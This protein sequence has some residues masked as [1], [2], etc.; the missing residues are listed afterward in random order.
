M[1]L[2][3][4]NPIFALALG[5]YFQCQWHNNHRW[6]SPYNRNRL[7]TIYCVL[8]RWFIQDYGREGY[9]SFTASID[10]IQYSLECCGV[11]SPSDYQVLNGT[12]NRD[13]YSSHIMHI[14]R[15]LLSILYNLI[16]F[17]NRTKFSNL[18]CQSRGQNNIWTIFDLDH[19]ISGLAAGSW[20]TS[21]S[22]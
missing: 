13:V 8:W 6:T 9:E 4:L 11:V 15:A 7:L 21:V 19:Y 14:I 10:W 16:S 22:I 3:M 18:N 5:Q 17:Q 1:N 12:I 20:P 2:K